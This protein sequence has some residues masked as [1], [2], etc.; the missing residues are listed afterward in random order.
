MF[1]IPRNWKGHHLRDDGK[2]KSCMT[3]FRDFV[4]LSLHIYLIEIKLMLSFGFIFRTPSWFDFSLSLLERI[5]YKMTTGL[6]FPFSLLHFQCICRLSIHRDTLGVFLPSN[7]MKLKVSFGYVQIFNNSFAPLLDDY[8]S[9]F[10]HVIRKCS[11]W[12]WVLVRQQRLMLEGRKVKYVF[13]CY[14]NLMLLGRF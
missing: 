13:F 12:G 6:F 14:F 7:Y 5:T 9:E 2:V 1:A 3:S 11:L 4:V 8:R 10:I